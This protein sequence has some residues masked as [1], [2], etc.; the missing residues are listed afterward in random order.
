MLQ[1][2]KG[3]FISEL[4]V[5]WVEGCYKFGVNYHLEAFF[6]AI[7]LYFFYLCGLH[8][9]FGVF[10][11][12]RFFMVIGIALGGSAG[13]L[14]EWFLVGNAPWSKPSVYQTGQFLFHG[15]YPILGYLLAHAPVPSRF[16]PHILKYMGLATII[17]VLGNFFENP[18]LRKL[19]FLFLP[20]VVFAGLYYFIY[21]LATAPPRSWEHVSN[22]SRQPSPDKSVDETTPVA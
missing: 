8:G 7:P 12:S 3:V 2:L 20:L 11:K 9:L 18:H 4:F 14:M 15:A 6:I 19:W 21:R 13:L 22:C 5:L 17:V 1:F 16:W 10:K